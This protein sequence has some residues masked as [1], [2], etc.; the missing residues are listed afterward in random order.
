MPYATVS[1]S[2]LHKTYLCFN[3]AMQ[4]GRRSML[5]YWAL[6]TTG[7]A[8]KQ[9]SVCLSHQDISALKRYRRFDQHGK[10]LL[11]LQNRERD[12]L[13]CIWY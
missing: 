11:I 2:A 5:F 10:H 9:P 7:K 13:P 8:G 1:A 4:F 6:C 3:N 12:F